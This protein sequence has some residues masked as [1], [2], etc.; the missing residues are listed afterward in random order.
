[1]ADVSGVQ[2]PS[3][4]WKIDKT[5]AVIVLIPIVLAALDPAQ[6]EPTIR[7]ATSAF[8]STLPFILFAILAV[9]YMKA[10]G[11]ENLLSG[12][13]QGRE[14][15]MIVLAALV[16]GLS[17]FC[18]CQVIPF[19]AALLAMG[20]PL[21]A[22]MAFWLS[23]PLMDPAMF[24]IT[25]GTLGIGFATAKLGFAVAIGLLGGFTVRAF[26]SSVLFANPL[27]KEQVKSCC[28]SS[29]GG[30]EGSF[31]GAVKWKFWGEAH[32]RATFREAAFENLFFLGKWLAL[33]YMIEALM[34]RYIPA[35]LIAQV[36][37][38][39]GL[40]P[41]L[42]GAIVGAPAYLNGYAA[43][44]LVDALLEQGMSNGAAMAF[45]IAGGISSI[46]AAVAVWALVKPRVFAAYLG[47]AVVGAILAG[48]GWS[49]IA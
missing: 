5:I 25:A 38:G 37:G 47:I 24:S 19:I 22:V 46:P 23:S 28:S 45:V 16:G 43:V 15:R 39:T 36:L 8:L 33:A 3:K 29:C 14:V 30:D 49:A 4:R 27:K 34:L 35:E 40:G 12:A 31:S 9:A 21:S 48:I 44:P 18:S 20:A 2:P 7:F 1:M 32:R 17:P 11:A 26:A 41:I 13:F 6:I 10:T 42:L